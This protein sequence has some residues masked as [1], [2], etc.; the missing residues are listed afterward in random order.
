MQNKKTSTLMIPGPVEVSPAVYEALTAPIASHVSPKILEAHGAALEKMRKVWLASD[1]S[2]PFIIGGSGTIAMEMAATNVVEPGDKVVVMN[3]G[4]F[5][6]RMALMLERRGVEVHSIF[7]EEIGA[8]PS[9]DALS[10][11]LKN[12]DIKAVFGTHVDTSTGVRLDAEVVAKLAREAGARSVFDGVCATAGEVFRM[13]EWGADVYFTASQKAIAL[14]PGLALM[15]VS[16]DG[17]EA[18]KRMSSLP[19]L[20]LDWMEWLPVMK[21]YEERRGSYFSTPPTHLI[22][23]LDIS[24][25]HILNRGIENV[26]DD[27]QKAADLFRATFEKMGLV[28]VPKKGLAANTLSAVYYGAHPGIVQALKDRGFIIA[29]GLHPEIKAQYFRIGHMGY[30]VGEGNDDMKGLLNALENL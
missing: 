10:E 6:D 21:A 8:H 22:S 27:H 28:L 25:G 4:Y 18:R 14:P 11:A 2:Q 17:I 1:D 3:S 24:L 30:S 16:Q 13:Q 9:L 5:G 12:K 29:G 19:P 20:S 7:A 15:V 23:A 26:F